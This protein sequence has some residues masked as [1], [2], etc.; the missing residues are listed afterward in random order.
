[1][2]PL[3]LAIQI[4]MNHKSLFNKFIAIDWSG[5]AARYSSGISVACYDVIK[6][7]LCLMKPSR[8]MKWS[9]D[10]VSDWIINLCNSN[11]KIFIGIDANL[12]YEQ[13]TAQKFIGE[14]KD[15]FALWQK[16]DEVCRDTAN[17]Y[18]EAIWHDKRY[19]DIYWVS[20]KTPNNIALKQRATEIACRESGYGNPESPFKLIGAKQVGRGGLAAMRMAHHLHQTLG[21]KIAFWPFATKTESLNAQIVM[22][23]IYPRLFIKKVGLGSAKIRTYNQLELA[24]KEYTPKG[25]TQANLSDHDTDALIS[26]IGLAHISNDNPDILDISNL[27]TCSKIEGWIFDV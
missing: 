20:G 9:R 1:M 12:G 23:E 27:P 17:F 2:F 24:L 13:T 11:D 3:S 22:T 10:D 5:S 6:D 7:N 4:F 19:K 14:K 18:A 8:Q 26:A 21:K 16:I 25:I 15:I